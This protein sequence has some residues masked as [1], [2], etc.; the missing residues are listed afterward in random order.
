MFIGLS[1]QMHKGGKL[2]H[3]HSHLMELSQEEIAEYGPNPVNFDPGPTLIITALESLAYTM[4]GLLDRTGWNSKEFSP[5]G[6][7]RRGL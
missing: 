7:F 4:K 2:R 6:G 5:H 3:R 1:Q